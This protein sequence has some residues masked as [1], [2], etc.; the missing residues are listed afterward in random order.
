MANLAT[1]YRHLGKFTEAEKLEIQVLDAMNPI[2][3]AP[4]VLATSSTTTLQETVATIQEQTQ[5]SRKRKQPNF[6]PT[7]VNRKV[8]TAVGL[9]G[10]P[11]KKRPVYDYV[12]VTE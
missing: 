3:S 7:L 10:C 12:L 5:P 6:A 9:D 1:T 4:L 11:L 2:I 8:P